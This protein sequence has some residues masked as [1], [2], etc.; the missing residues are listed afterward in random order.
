[1]VFLASLE[2]MDGANASEMAS[3]KRYHHQFFPD[4]VV[5]EKGALSPDEQQ[6]LTEWGHQLTES[7]RAF[8]NMNIVTWDYETGKVEA[9]TDPR[10]LGEAEV[11][12]Y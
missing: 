5:F 3:L 1:M 8:G 2:W 6:A 9:A 11:R 12:V 4:E 7:R 10:G